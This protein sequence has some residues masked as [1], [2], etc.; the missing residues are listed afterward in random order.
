MPVM[1][2]H[3][4]VLQW[5]G[6]GFTP[7][8]PPAAPLSTCKQPVM[9]KT[10]R[11]TLNAKLQH[12]HPD[13]SSA[14]ELPASSRVCNDILTIF[15]E[16]SAGA[17]ELGKVLLLLSPLLVKHQCLQPQRVQLDEADEMRNALLLLLL[18]KAT[19]SQ[20]ETMRNS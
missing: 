19:K 16:S 12:Y 20:T 4:G 7:Q 18:L 1:H 15:T 6:G 14:A 10:C 8:G 2:T 17:N 13:Q 5:F 3:V 9:S 11:C